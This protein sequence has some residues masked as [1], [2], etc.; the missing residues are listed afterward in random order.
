MTP[1]LF[2]LL[3]V[4]PL[5]AA[6]AAAPQFTVD[7]DRCSPAR[8]QTLVGMNIG[9]VYLPPQLDQRV[10]SPGQFV[11]F[12]YRPGRLNIFVDPK[13]WIGRISCG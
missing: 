5:L 10:I 8:H 11:D 1:R 9:E 2:A 7:D 3:S 4:M 13:G 6:C 12:A